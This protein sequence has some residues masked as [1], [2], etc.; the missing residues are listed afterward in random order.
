M[1]PRVIEQIKRTYPQYAFLFEP[2]AGG[3]GDDLLQLLIRAS[4]P[5]AEYTAERFNAELAQTKYFNETSDNAQRFDKKTKAQR[6]AEIE[7]KVADIK[8]SYGDVFTDP[9]EL[10]RVATAATRQGLIGNRLKYFVYASAT[11]IG[12]QP[13][14]TKTADADKLRNIAREYGYPVTE[15]EITAVLTGNPYN[16]QVYTEATFLNKAKQAAKGLY[17]HLAPQLDAGLSLED[18]FKN[19]R[20]YASEILEL[21]PTQIDFVKDPKWSRAF[22]TQDKGQMSLSDWVRE[23]KT[24]QDYGWRFTNQA[25]KQVSGVVSVLERAFGLRT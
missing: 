20:A 18:I 25:N 2:G 15:D 13:G 10:L 5:G 14:V 3:Y 11:K 6:D 12:A 8:A 4:T 1:D 21:D 23:L 19:Y 7:A 9:A 24:N 16:G 22:G 17:S